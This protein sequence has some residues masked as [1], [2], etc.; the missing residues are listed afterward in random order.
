MNIVV[1]SQNQREYIKPM[2]EALKGHNV[3]YVL[4]RCTDGS[5]EEL[6]GFTHIVN[7]EGTGFLAGRMRDLGAWVHGYKGPILFLD[8]DKV[9]TGDLNVIPTLGF[10]CVLLGVANDRRGFADGLIPW[11]VDG[12]LKNPHNGVY[13]CGI[14]LSQKAIDTAREMCACRIFHRDFDEN[15]GEEDRYLGDVLGNAGLTIG[16]SSAVVLQGELTPA[17]EATERIAKNFMVRLRLS[18]RIA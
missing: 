8:G 10:D 15:W 14:W 2:L 4:D 16:F 7:E 1:I 5:E 17:E 12:D 11:L 6:T 9:P 3:C 18:G 13:S